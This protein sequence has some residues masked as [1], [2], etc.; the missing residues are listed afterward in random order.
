MVT[1]DLLK[2]AIQGRVARATSVCCN[3]WSRNCH[4]A[5]NE[6]NGCGGVAE[7]KVGR[8]GS[9]ITGASSTW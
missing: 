8:N 1:E 4:V 9:G 7:R 5:M 2:K 6:V 3:V